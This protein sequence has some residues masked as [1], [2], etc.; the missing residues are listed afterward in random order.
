MEALKV[1]RATFKY[2][3]GSVIFEI[4]VETDDESERDRLIDLRDSGDFETAVDA[5]LATD[6][7]KQ[8]RDTIGF[9]N[10]PLPPVANNSDDEEDQ[11]NYAIVVL[12]V[13]GGSF[14][15]F[16]LGVVL[17]RTCERRKRGSPGYPDGGSYTYGDGA[18]EMT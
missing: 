7:N 11:F 18:Q 10:T 1:Q 12:T 13:V 4:T 16:I 14:F 5:Q 6:A 2:E 3:C 17:W 9:L 15:I 8:L